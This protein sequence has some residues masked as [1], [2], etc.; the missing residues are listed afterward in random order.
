M[1]RPDGWATRV[2]GGFSKVEALVVAG[3]IGFLLAIVLPAIEAA[4]PYRPPTIP[5]KEP[6]EAYRVYL[7]NGFSV[8]RPPYWEVMSGEAPG[9][10]SGRFEFWAPLGNKPG[11]HLR[12]DWQRTD[13]GIDPKAVKV[14]FQGRPAW[15]STE[16]RERGFGSRSHFRATLVAPRDNVWLTIHYAYFGHQSAVP[17]MMWKY[18]ETV[19]CP[20]ANATP[21]L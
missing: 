16:R 1:K 14:V 4:R 9:G 8:V 15:L 18:F 17:D 11:G 12:I 10:S 21:S 13:P 20:S 19:T 3:I 2:R 6:S 7:P 5:D